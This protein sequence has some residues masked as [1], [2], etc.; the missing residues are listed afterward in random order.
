MNSLTT[1]YMNEI[2]PEE[3]IRESNAIEDEFSAEGIQDG[4]YALGFA[5]AHAIQDSVD[6]S[7]VRKVHELA[8]HRVAPSI[9]GKLRQVD[10]RVGFHIAPPYK[11]VIFLLEKLCNSQLY[12]PDTAKHWHIEFERIHPFEDGNG[13]TGR[14]L[15]YAQC[16]ASGKEFGVIKAADRSDYYQWFRQP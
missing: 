13:R 6:V 16:I 9:A 5:V 8:M 4:L 1:N 2:N 7:V 3:L 15:Y 10:V 12:S 11:E 14:I